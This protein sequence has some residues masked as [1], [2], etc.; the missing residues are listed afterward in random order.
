MTRPSGRRWRLA[1]DTALLVAVVLTVSVAMP[2]EAAFTSAGTATSGVT[3]HTLSTPVLDCLPGGLFT[4]TVT[5]T[6]P[7][8]TSATTPDPY[9]SVP[10]SYL[11]DGYEIHRATG[12]GGFSLLTSAPGRTATSYVDSPGGF[13]TTHRYKIRT[14]N[15][16]WT[17]PFSNEVT[18][19]VVSV[20]TTTC[21]N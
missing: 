6:W 8:V 17:S 10:S 18:A 15:E 9:A 16:G 4:T 12:G 2:A 11:A 1:R 20:V 7:P 3:T 19:T 21:T 5:L 13:I 14:R